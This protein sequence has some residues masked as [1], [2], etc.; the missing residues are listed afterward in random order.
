METDKIDMK[1]GADFDKA[2][3]EIINCNSWIELQQLIHKY[4]PF[5]SYSRTLP[6]TY[7]AEELIDKM[8]R[9]RTG[10]PIQLITRVCGLR[11]KVAEL[12]LGSNYG[13]PWSKV[14]SE[15]ND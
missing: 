13:E 15:S 6:K 4:A 3:I 10:S 12:V 2:T 5:T 1:V 9:V 11:A 14:N 8:E 7:Q